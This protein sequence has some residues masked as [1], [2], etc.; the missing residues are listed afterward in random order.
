[1]GPQRFE[2]EAQVEAQMATPGAELV[3]DMAK[4]DGG[5][6]VLGAGGKMG[7]TLARL[8][9]NAAP[10]KQVIAVARFSDPDVRA[11]LE[12][13]GVETRTADLLDRNQVEALP[14]LANVVFMAGRKFGSQGAEDL[15]WAMNT[16]V[17]ALVAETFR[18][19]RIVALSTG[20][21][22]EFA[23]PDAPSTE[24][25]ALN[26]PGEYA[27]SCV[28][29][30]RMFEYFSKQYETPGRLIRLNYAIDMRYGVLHDIA[31]KVQNGQ[32]IDLSTGHV[33]IIWQGEANSQILRCLSQATTPTSPINISGDVVAVRWLATE[34]G[35]RLG[36]SPRFTGTEAASGWVVDTSLAKSLFGP[37]KVSLEQMIVWTADWFSRGL[38]G[39]GKPTHYEVRNGAY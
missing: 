28:G 11:R 17:P 1:M 10:D 32:E 18:D 34:M 35:Q 20:C 27:N 16:H 24:R 19:S 31:L 37:H 12:A 26:P 21:V 38:G 23:S 7:P 5:L 14:K 39:H 22:Y 4:L 3:A 6:L 30:E 8:A 33:N 15:T 13:H 36:K 25:A 29:R 9:K 2:D